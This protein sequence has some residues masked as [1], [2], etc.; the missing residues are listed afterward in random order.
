[1]RSRFEIKLPSLFWHP[2]CH[3]SDG[4]HLSDTGAEI[5]LNR[6]VLVFQGTPGAVSPMGAMPNECALDSFQRVNC[7]VTIMVRE[8]S[9]AL[10]I[11]SSGMS[12]GPTAYGTSYSSKVVAVA[13]NLG[14]TSER[15]HP[16][17]SP[18]W[19]CG[20]T[21]K[22]CRSCFFL[23]TPVRFLRWVPSLRWVPFFA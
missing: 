6:L 3:L 23:R 11:Y 5:Q 1:M 15:S 8:R 14:Y 18:R 7:V 4:C 2:R 10:M 17:P 19:G 13:P 22:S 9:G 12:K 21:M 16:V 20:N